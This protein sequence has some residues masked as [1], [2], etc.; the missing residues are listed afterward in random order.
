L[1]LACL[2]GLIEHRLEQQPIFMIRPGL[3]QIGREWIMF[4]KAKIYVYFAIASSV[5]L[6]IILTSFHSAG[7]SAISN[8]A[9]SILS[10]PVDYYGK[11]IDVLRLFGQ[12]KISETGRNLV[13]GNG[14]YHGAGVLVDRNS[15]SDR[16]YI[17]VADTG[18][19]R[20]LGF[21]FNCASTSTCQM[22]GSTPA[23]IVIGQPDMTTAS[24]NG[25][26]N[27]GFNRSPAASTLCLLGYPLANNTAESWMRVNIDVDS[28]GNLYVPDFWNNRVLKYNQPLSADKADG[29]GDAVA[30]Y[31]WGQ[32]TM[33]SNGRNRGANYGNVSAPD[34]H[35]LW[36]SF[37]AP[38]FDHVTSRGVSVDASGNVW[39]A[40]T[41]NNR[42]LRFP[43][44][45][46]NADLVLGQSSFTNS[47][48]VPNGALNRMCT[49]TLARIHPTTG[50]LYV[51]DEYPAPF[52][53]RLLVFKPPFTN[54]MTAYKTIIPNQGGP[55]TNWGGWDGTG[56][57]RFQS[58][59]FIFN[60]YKQGEYA[61]GEIWLNEHEANRTLLID[62][63]GNIVK[64]I[65]AQNQ[66][67]RGGDS[68]Y[69]P[70]CGSIYDGNHLWWPGGSIGMDNANNIY[71]ADE[72]FQTV[73]R[74]ALPYNTYQ[75]GGVT[76][77]PDANGVLFPKGPNHRS[78]ARLGES[79]G[80]TV[81]GDQLLVRDEGM[82]LKAYNNYE[83]LPFGADASYVLSGGLQARNWLSGGTDDA[84]RLWLTGEHGQ[85]R[86]Y[87]LPITSNAQ[88][89]IADFVKL[90]WA[91]TGLEVTRPGGSEYVQVGAM[92]FDPIHPAMYIVDAGGTRIFRVKNYS[93]FANKLFVDM[94]IGQTNKTEVR[95]N[96]GLASP[97][98]STLCAVSQI[99]FDKLGNLFVVDN[100]YECQGNHRIVVYESSSLDS[101][102]TLFP[103]LAATRVF[104]APGFNQVGNCAYNTVDQPGSPVSLAFN[105]K[106]QMV[107][108]N[109]GYYGDSS[110]RQLKQL[111]FYSDPLAKQTPDASI[112]IYMGTPGELAFDAKDN[113][114]IQDHT[115]YKVWMINLSCDPEWLS[116]LPGATIPVLPPC[117]YGSTA[118]DTPTPIATSTPILNCNAVYHGP[119]VLNNGLSM[120][121]INQ[122]GVPLAVQ[123]VFV[124]WNHDKGHSLGAD[125]TLSLQQASLDGVSF[126]NG[127]NAGPGFVITPSASLSIPTGSS[128]M[129][130]NF[131]Q[132][133]DILDG[134]EQIL[135][136]LKTNGCQSYPIDSSTVSVTNTPTATQ[137][138]TFTPTATPPYSYDPLYLSLT[139]SQTI[140]GV[141]SSDED[142]LYFDGTN[143]SLFFDGSDVGVGTPDLFAFS[144][145]D[146]DSILMSFTANV[147]VN[148]ITATPQDILRFDATSLGS[149]TAGTFSMYLDGSDVGLDTTSENIDSVSLLPDGR[150]LISTTG[151]P[152]VPGVTGK[153]ED[154]L[155]FTPTS[156]GDTTNGTWSMYFDGSDVGLADSSNE[157]VDALDV[158]SNGNIYLS[159]LGDFAVTGLSGADEDVFVCVPTSIGDVTA[160][161]Y[162][163][164]LYFDG[165]T[166]GL[167]AN[168]VD[169]INLLTFGPIPTTTPSKTPT[170]TPTSTRTST[171]TR[172]S[173]ITRTP[174]STTTSSTL[175][176]TRTPSFTPTL[177]RTATS[178]TG[179]SF[180]NTPTRTASPL[181]TFTITATSTVG[182][183]ITNTPTQTSSPTPTR[184][185]TSTPTLAGSSL[186]FLPIEDAY[187]AS[188]SPTTNAGS[189]TT[190]QVDNSPI[191]HFLLK[192]DVSGLNGKQVVSAKLRLY[193]VDPASKGGDF[194]AVSDS[195]WQEETLTWNN[196]PA[197][198]PT[199]LASLGS[200]SANNWYEVDL[201][202][203]ITGDGTY[204]LRITSTSS[205]GAD[206]SSKEG[207]NPP[208]LVIMV[209]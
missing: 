74:Y 15:P 103:G 11:S 77:L 206:Y 14:I 187:I 152:S 181:A 85:I 52:L 56:S 88:A 31:V 90:Y 39:V 114:L 155:A 164:S 160:C 84:N 19:S 104:N 30:D 102:T 208:Q 147:T 122:T 156:L 115:W 183:S 86:I 166:W 135:I 21:N 13:D 120:S 130:F 93:Q 137:T 110:Q 76:C 131:H 10:T 141:S 2:R 127:N 168:D 55:F 153:D 68:V 100:S 64:V 101:T 73:Y 69:Y 204:S 117:Q 66:F 26:S 116:Y 145:L 50:D 89:P 132:S 37:G 138:V 179:P 53:T 49:P 121:L 207:T 146:S 202:S 59:G 28:Q 105:S 186:T 92:A 9:G 34:N 38:F 191:K 8:P 78:S 176:P 67:L 109:D 24:C 58:T 87:Q 177:T 22:D 33:T 46:T 203:L 182:P 45:S 136:N 150:I 157:D 184:T 7:A 205:D 163:T 133:Y 42:V 193:N 194:Y 151:G 143:W 63:N 192:F 165:S 108:G 48:C 106:N 167:A 1:K 36:I 125:K 190:L 91:D 185:A 189:A 51:L 118:T 195:A 196:A 57:Y 148:G 43:P 201:T 4:V 124:V 16:L 12:E 178:T 97:N 144:L 71:L 83:N 20:I 162:S 172:T 61:T 159:T 75:A 134:S 81:A 72:M 126:W 149:S 171:P 139:S 32:D 6:G 29:K 209:Q 173:T 111:W 35:S 65:G 200:V 140:G 175:T 199:L 95:C 169:A 98:A 170:R 60:T 27:L 112:D 62:L 154:I 70:G 44:N 18:N 119:L 3:V 40:D 128:T 54:G 94:V 47:G 123:D 198:L 197:A 180:T 174:V 23:D 82:R 96:Q 5:L 142:I 129:L 80:M 99:K 107:V 79:V 188:G 158:T 41:F 25:D 17:Y 113:L 161:N